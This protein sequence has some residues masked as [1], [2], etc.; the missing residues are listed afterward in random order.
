[1]PASDARRR[2]IRILARDLARRIYI[3]EVRL[4]VERLAVDLRE[5]A[6]V[7]KAAA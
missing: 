5:S 3:G 6:P 2:L 4:A 7:R 1:M